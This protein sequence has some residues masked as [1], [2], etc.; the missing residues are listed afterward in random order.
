MA[1]AGSGTASKRLF[2][3]PT[4]RSERPALAT[5][6]SFAVSTMDYPLAVLIYE[7]ID[8]HWDSAIVQGQHRIFHLK[9]DYDV[10]A[11]V[12]VRA[13][14][15]CAGGLAVLVASQPLCLFLGMV[16]G[17]CPTLDPIWKT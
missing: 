9:P 5:S 6:K 1:G 2:P 12:G 13:A 16:A 10:A 7:A 3:L 4:S 11:V 8:S 14:A 15:G 17:A